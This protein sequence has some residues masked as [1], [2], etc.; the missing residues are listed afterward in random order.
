M[1]AKA[2]MAAKFCLDFSHLMLALSG[3]STGIGGAPFGRQS[4]GIPDDRRSLAGEWVMT[5]YNVVRF[6]LKP[7]GEQEFTD[8]HRNAQ[9]DWPG[10]RHFIAS[11]GWPRNCSATQT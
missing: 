10:A 6:R 2:T 11:R 9:V 1:Q 3:P 5:A 7:G 4:T 8:A